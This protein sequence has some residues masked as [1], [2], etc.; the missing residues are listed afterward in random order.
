MITAQAAISSTIVHSV[1]TKT[2]AITGT[3]TSDTITI[4]SGAIIVTTKAITITRT[5]TG[6][7][8]SGTITI[9]AGTIMV[10]TIAIT[11]TRTITGTKTSATITI[12]TH[13]KYSIQT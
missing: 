11:K 12:R 8:S 1:T 4:H 5:I 9:H 3:I 7:K 2:I 13:A 6:T 10:T